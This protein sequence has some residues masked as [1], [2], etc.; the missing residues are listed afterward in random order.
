MPKRRTLAQVFTCQL[1]LIF[2]RDG[3]WEYGLI[4]RLS[5]WTCR[6]PKHRRVDLWEAHYWGTSASPWKSMKA[7]RDLHLCFSAPVFPNSQLMHK[8]SRQSLTEAKL[9]RLNSCELILWVLTIS[10]C[11]IDIYNWIFYLRGCVIF[12][13]PRKRHKAS[14]VT[15]GAR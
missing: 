13:W 15:Y 1:A 2:S 14:D 3:F 4:G 7:M 5:T 11:D 10:T 12:Q 8:H 6:S 9:L